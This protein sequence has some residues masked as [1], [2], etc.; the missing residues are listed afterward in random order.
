LI[1]WINSFDDPFC[2]IVSQLPQD[3]LNGVV[4]SHLVGYIACST[5]D[6]EK[7]FDLLC[8]PE[9]DFGLKP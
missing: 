1:D 6:R 7:I 5:S 9:Q 4:L 3:L 2:V 8:Y